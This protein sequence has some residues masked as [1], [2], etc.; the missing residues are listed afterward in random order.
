MDEVT[1]PDDDALAG[2]LARILRPRTEPP[3]EVL[4]AARG[5]YSWRT[6][7]AELAALVSDSL[8]DAPAGTV[9][10]GGEPR[11]VTFETDDVTVEVEVDTSRGARRLLGRIAPGAAAEVR[12]RVGNED[13]AAGRA[14]DLGRFELPLPARPRVVRLRCAFPDGT[15]LETASLAL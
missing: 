10:A 6:V 9:R 7:D 5:L 3:A 13:V 12:L 14:D 11:M 8:L 2:D 15:A 4:D 1:A